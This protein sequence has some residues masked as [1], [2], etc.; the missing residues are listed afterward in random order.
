VIATAG[1][2]L[3]ALLPCPQSRQEVTLTRLPSTVR[4]GEVIS[5]TLRIE[6][7]QRVGEPKIPKVDG[8]RIAVGG[9]STG[10][11]MSIINGRQ[12]VSY[13]VSY[14]IQLVGL[15]L[16][17]FKIPPIEIVVGDKTYK[18][19]ERSL[20]VVKNITGA[21]FGSLAIV[22]SSR[23]VYVH[24]PIRFDIECA[25]DASLELVSGRAGN[26]AQYYAVQLEAEWLTKMDGGEAIHVPD[27]DTDRLVNVVLNQTLQP[28]DVSVARG[29]GGKSVR[30]FR[31][32]KSV[33]PTRAGVHKLV[34]PIMRFN[35]LQGVER[36]VFGFPTRGQKEYIVA[37]K[38]LEIE[39][40][41]LPTE[42][43]P[44]PFYGGVG[45]F[46]IAAAFDKRTVNVGGSVKLILTIAGTGNMEHLRVP[47]LADLPGFHR[48]GKIENRTRRSVVVTY[49]LAPKTVEVGRVASIEWNYFD[50]TP[51]VE[52]YVAV[53]TDE[54]T[55]DV[56]ARVGEE[57]L[58]DLP[59]ER[60]KAVE[61][62]VDDIFDVKLS[63]GAVR[64]APPPE[65][66]MA[67]LTSLL[68]WV[69]GVLGMFFWRARR[70]AMADMQGRRAR[71]ALRK[72]EAAVGGG[73]E[74]LDA[75]VA[76]LADRLG[77]EPA[78]VIGP[79]LADRL[80]TVGIGDPC[81]TQAQSLVDQGVATRYGGSGDLDRDLVIAT[82][83]ALERGEPVAS[84]I[85]GLLLA[86]VLCG[87]LVGDIDA[88]GDAAAPTAAETAYR[89]RDFVA[90][91][92]LFREAADAGDRRAAYNLGNCLFRQGLFAR[93]L[94]AYEKARLAM[95][96]DPELLANIRL[97]R[98]RLSLGTAEGEAFAQTIA[99]IRE[100]YTPRER[101]WLCLL[102]NVIAAALVCFG[103]RRLR[104]LGIILAIPA[105]ILVVEVA[106]LQ[107]ARPAKGI[108]VAPMTAMRAEPSADLEPIKK[109]HS[110]VAVEVLGSSPNSTW[111][112]VRIDGRKGFVPAAA[113]IVVD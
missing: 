10:S 74:P 67:L 2:F 75:L 60:A 17:K 57:S 31:Y 49:D 23:R 56:R 1:L 16:G 99:T 6:T 43:R 87:G 11:N 42:G 80:R 108:I 25:I 72:F 5:A 22:P 81:A 48:L 20:E 101:F 52:K 55:I 29:E 13:E 110:G 63:S 68:P 104:I 109:L 58:P 7:R 46:T 76:Y 39:V 90:A 73:A 61:E 102:G 105:L 88:Q 86:A 26:G 82:V 91:A 95:P 40:L 28:S 97:V 54:L 79:D 24:E 19:R 34:A 106:V 84:A 107:P 96:R 21:N 100:S 103:G 8:L 50:T 89:A 36:D 53:E 14:P 37:E 93:A 45:R 51:G 112:Q 83:R 66:G 47:E 64:L 111:T 69:V 77:C 98:E 78:A 44:D 9:K 92:A 30:V 12:T 71:G 27:T 38:P 59:G 35:V 65:T 32:H 113:L 62:G 41:P 18:T 3:T 85:T 4:L 33:L 15:R 70:R 94:A